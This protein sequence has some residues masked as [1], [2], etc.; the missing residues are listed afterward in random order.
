MGKMTSVIVVNFGIDKF[1]V[2]RPALLQRYP[3]FTEN[4]LY[5]SSIARNCIT[6][7]YYLL[8]H[9]LLRAS[10]KGKPTTSVQTHSCARLPIQIDV[11]IYKMHPQQLYNFL[12]STK[13]MQPIFHRSTHGSEQ[14]R[15][16]FVTVKAD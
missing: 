12:K 1:S 6:I 2:Y 5:E 4:F 7:Y 16:S 14:A 13:Y 3:N 15:L 9:Q 10:Q 11:D 8:L